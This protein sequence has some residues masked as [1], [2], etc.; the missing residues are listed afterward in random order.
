MTNQDFLVGFQPNEVYAVKEFGNS[1]KLV[2]PD[3]TVVGTMGVMNSTRK[4]A[5]KNGEALH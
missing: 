3:E 2:Q 4:T 1:V 5:L